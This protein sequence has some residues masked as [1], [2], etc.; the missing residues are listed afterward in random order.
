MLSEFLTFF[1]EMVKLNC[2]VNS[3]RQYQWDRLLWKWL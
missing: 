3:T 2:T 1:D